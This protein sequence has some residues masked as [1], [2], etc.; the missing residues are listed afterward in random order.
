MNTVAVQGSALTEAVLSGEMAATTAGGA[1]TLIGVVPM[2]LDADSAGFA[3]A[4]NA[5]GAA[6]LAVA[7]EQVGQRAALAGGQNLASLGYLAREV[8]SAAALRL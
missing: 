2:A 6:Y 8:A 3:A 7:A 4:L 5:A 1:A